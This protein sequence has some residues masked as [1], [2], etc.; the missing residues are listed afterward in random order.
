MT[1][2]ILTSSAASGHVNYRAPTLPTASAVGV[3]CSGS[4]PVWNLGGIAHLA[5]QGL[6]LGYTP[7][8]A[9][10]TTPGAPINHHISNPNPSFGVNV[11][12]NMGL[13]SCL[14]LGDNPNLD[15]IHNPAWLNQWAQKFWEF[16]NGGAGG[17][18]L[19]WTLQ[20]ILNADVGALQAWIANAELEYDRAQDYV[21]VRRPGTQPLLRQIPGLQLFKRFLDDQ[22]ASAAPTPTWFNDLFIDSFHLNL[23]KGAYVTSMIGAACMYGIDPFDMP[24]DMQTASGFTVPEAAYVKSC[25]SDTIKNFSRAGVDTSGWA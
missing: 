13:Y 9:K 24:N 7:A 11:W 20:P 18:V 3:G 23:G 22:I 17:E 4:D 5:R 2:A 15:G 14:H 1:R 16:G 25:V 21:N 10:S 6:G 8:F 12:Q 19:L